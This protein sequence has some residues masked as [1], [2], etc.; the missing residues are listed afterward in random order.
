M[1]EA[2]QEE[3]QVQESKVFNFAEPGEEPDLRDAWGRSSEDDEKMDFEESKYMAMTVPQL[4]TEIKT[5]QAA[6][7]EFDTPNIKTKRDAVAALVADDYD[8][9]QNP[10]D[11]EE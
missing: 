11:P 6:G 7:R 10:P 9:A 4:K 1:S 2:P 8:V 5:R 3:T